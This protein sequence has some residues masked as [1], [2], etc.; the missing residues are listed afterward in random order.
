[1]F[2]RLLW[3]SGRRFRSVRFIIVATVLAA[4]LMPA[5]VFAQWPAVGTITTLGGTGTAGYNGDLTTATFAQLNGPTGVAV[6]AGGNV[7]IAD[8]NNHRVRRIA[9]NG[10]ITTA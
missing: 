6:D 8:N 7:Y 3:P 4:G 1:M 9:P 10:I 5:H 2:R